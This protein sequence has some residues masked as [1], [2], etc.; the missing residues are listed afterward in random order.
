MGMPALRYDPPAPAPRTPHLRVVKPSTRA[1]TSASSRPSARPHARS[2]A[3]VFQAFVFFA[4][5]VALVST[6]G[7][8]RVW[9]SVQA[10]QASIDSA[11][12]RRDIKLEQYQGDVLEVQQSALA[13][14]SRVQA[15]AEGS[16]GMAAAKSV[17]YLDLRDLSTSQPARPIVAAAPRAAGVSGVVATALQA[18]ASEARVLL[19]GDVGLSSSE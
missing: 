4:V 8:G 17:S 19:V 15:I 5:V 2:N 11:N 1:R 9:M 6:L 18:A 10:T 7:L 12:L 13:T 3:S 16:M 14:P